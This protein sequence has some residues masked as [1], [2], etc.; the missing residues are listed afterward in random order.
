MS[1]DCHKFNVGILRFSFFNKSMEKLTCNFLINKYG[2]LNEHSR[3]PYG[4][5][6]CMIRKE[7]YTSNT[8]HFE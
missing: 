8:N 7:P 1:Q 4:V 5:E 6:I 3:I 2:I